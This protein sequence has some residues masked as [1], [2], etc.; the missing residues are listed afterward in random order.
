MELLN[1][2]QAIKK[3][4]ENMVGELL[5]AI[6]RD[7]QEW[8]KGWAHDTNQIPVN[9]VDGKPYEGMNAFN[10]L[11]QQG[12]YGYTDPRWVTKKEA[13]KLGVKIKKGEEPTLVAYFEEYG[14]KAES[15][16]D[17]KADENAPDRKKKKRIKEKV[18]CKMR[19]CFV[20]N[21]AQC[22]N[23]PERDKVGEDLTEINWRIE[24]LIKNCGVPIK[25]DG[26][27]HSYYSIETDSIHL[28]RLDHFHSI[29]DYYATFLHELAHSTAHENRLNRDVR[30][31]SEEDRMAEELRAE[32]A[33]MFMQREF[34]LALDGF[35]LEKHAFYIKGWLDNAGIIDRKQEFIYAVN[36]AE[37]ITDYVVENLLQADSVWSAERKNSRENM[38]VSKQ[39]DLFAEQ[40]KEVA[41]N[42]FQDY[43]LSVFDFAPDIYRKMGFSQAEVV[44]SAE[45][46]Q[47]A[48]Q[49]AER[50]G[51]S[52]VDA[53][54]Q[55]PQIFQSPMMVCNSFSDPER[56]FYV[57]SEI[58]NQENKPTIAL[59][60]FQNFYKLVCM[61]CSFY[62][63]ENEEHRKEFQDFLNKNIAAGSIMY[64]NKEKMQS[65]QSIGIDCPVVFH[66]PYSVRQWN[67]GIELINERIFQMKVY[68]QDIKSLHKEEI[69]K[70]YKRMYRNGLSDLQSWSKRGY[71]KSLTQDFLRTKPLVSGMYL[72]NKLIFEQTENKNK[73]EKD[74]REKGYRL[75]RVD[76]DDS[77]LAGRDAD[78]VI[79]NMPEGEYSGFQLTVPSQFL[80]DSLVGAYELAV[81]DWLTYRIQKNGEYVELTCDEL[82]SVLAGEQLGKEPQQSNPVLR[83]RAMLDRLEQN[84][85][86]QLKEQPYW[87][88]YF[89]LQPDD[90]NKKKR[91]KV[92]LSPNNGKWVRVNDTETWTDFDTAMNYARKHNKEG[93]SLLLTKDGGLTCIDLDE[94]INADGTYNGIAQKLT[95]ELGGTYTEKSVSGNGLHIFI[96]DD[97]LKDGT[98][99]STARTEQGELEVYDSA[100]I[101][102]LTGDMVSKTNEITKCPTATTQFLRETLGE[103]QKTKAAEPRDDVLNY[104][105]GSDSEVIDRIRKSKR[106]ADFDALYSG[107]GITGNASVDD[108]KLANI[109]AFFTN[110]DAEQSLRIMKSSASYRPNKSDNYY[111]HTIGK[112]ID[113]LSVRPTFGAKPGADAGK[114]KNDRGSDR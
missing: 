84:I 107:R 33:S 25:Y 49:S 69:D 45:C 104:S 3:M 67:D 2:Y 36:E 102:S 94:C 96:K 24:Q 65:L 83:S 14:K 70:I 46:I 52:H 55:L 44:V 26:R 74:L 103:R 40:V 97:V 91:D 13:K 73:F 12:R 48:L 105:M 47:N 87:G 7:P 53:V 43:Y 35:H 30:N 11:A 50:A 22:V 1:D 4:R 95:S 92:I 18:R 101:I 82:Q 80:N 106:G 31:L 51:Q 19:Y 41:E 77:M 10:L 60:K 29:N 108:M 54:A 20:Y 62:Q 23:F 114:G 6:D 68:N 71:Q 15:K 37:K 109:L 112:A 56:R 75:N 110:C 39:N 93:L 8:A 113:T 78:K 86:A 72:L 85:P 63:L 89:T 81:S 66:S 90:P 79:I 16:N 38:I 34:G 99:K 88:V 17:R 98:Y 28:P 111:K 76:L 57:Y 5:D 58:Q 21:A 9:G 100:H 32:L 61:S 42:R 64:A 59:I 27:D